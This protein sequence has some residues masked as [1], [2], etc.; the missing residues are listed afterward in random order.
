MTKFLR[1]VGLCSCL[2]GLAAFGTAEDK[3]KSKADKDAPFSDE[4]FVKKAASSD[5]HE[6]AAGK[7][8]K[9]MAKDPEVKKFAAKMIED[10]TKASAELKKAA[11]A[12]GIE[13]PTAMSDED[14]AAVDKLK[15][16]KGDAFDKAYLADQMEGHH[17]ASMLFTKASENAKNQDLKNFA[18]RTLPVIKG[19]HQMLHVMTGKDKTKS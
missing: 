12:A 19:H 2:V 4:M 15:E 5:M 1:G 13:V 17:K 14:K 18:A 9:E 10:H 6:I 7:L 8:A 11:K 3:A 16:A